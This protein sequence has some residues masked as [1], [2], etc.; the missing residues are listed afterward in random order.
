MTIMKTYKRF[1]LNFVKGEGTYLYEKNGDEYLDFVAGVA[2]NALGHSNEKVIEAIK[3]QSE[4]LIHISNLYYDDNQ[5]MLADKLVELS[6]HESVFFCNSGTEAIEGALK[7]ARKYG[8][9]NDKTKILYLKNSF[10]GRTLGALSVTGQEK[11]QKYYKPLIGDVEEVE[12]NNIDDLKNKMDDKV[13]G[14]IVEPIQGEGGINLIDSD[15]LNEIKMLCDKN[16][17]LLI[18]DEVQS[19]IG[20]TGKFFAYQNYDV[21]PDVVAMAKGL[22]SG[23]PIGAFMVNKKADVFDYGDHG[24]TFGGNPLVT[25]VSNVVVDTISDELF[26][27]EVKIK[28]K[29]LK[30]KLQSMESEYAFIKGIRGIGLLLGIQLDIDM[31]ESKEIIEKA[32]EQKLLII[33][34]GVDVIRVVPA[35]TVSVEEIDEFIIKLK[36]TLDSIV[37]EKKL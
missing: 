14:I 29:Y 1:D 20:R 5:I 22:G 6:N 28:G 3:K 12:F 23:V 16:D 18:F 26:L 21:V 31:I 15:F 25:A 24:C 11:Y 7:V 10:H 2:V 34:A 4:K 36:N 17:A 30:D 27:N 33:G 8:Y 9:G 13:C 19:G 35:L 32:L 37:L